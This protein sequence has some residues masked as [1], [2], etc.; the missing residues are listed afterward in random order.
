MGVANRNSEK[1]KLPKLKYHIEI[2]NHIYKCRSTLATP[3]LFKAN[4]SIKNKTN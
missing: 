4:Y 1:V 3:Q 2:G